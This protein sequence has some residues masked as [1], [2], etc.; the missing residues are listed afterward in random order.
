[1]G[2]STLPPG[3]HTAT[4]MALS[5]Q[6]P[7]QATAQQSILVKKK[8]NHACDSKSERADAGVKVVLD[9]S[10]FSVARNPD[11]IC[12]WKVKPSLPMSVKGL[13]LSFTVPALAADTAYQFTLTVIDGKLNSNPSVHSALIKKAADQADC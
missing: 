13:M 7:R 8:M 10:A 5:G 9:A 2:L 12:R 1:M 4:V 3:Q 6:G 11:L